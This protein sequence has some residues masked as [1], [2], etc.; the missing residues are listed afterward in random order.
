MWVAV[1]KDENGN[2]VETALNK[3]TI[4]QIIKPRLEEAKQV[5]KEEYLS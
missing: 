3:E 5:V 4:D 1:T 2:E